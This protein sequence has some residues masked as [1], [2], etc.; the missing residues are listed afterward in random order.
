MHLD[1]ERDTAAT[2][3]T[4]EDPQAII[5]ARIWMCKYRSLAPL[6]D[7]R[8]LQALEIASY[9]DETLELV[10]GLAAL[11]DL[12]ILH[13]PKVTD[14]GPLARLDQLRSLALETTPRW[15]SSGKV[16]E[17][18]SLDPLSQLPHLSR[19][20]LYMA[21]FLAAAALTPSSAISP[22]ARCVSASTRRRRSSASCRSGTGRPLAGSRFRQERR[23]CSQAKA[24][25]FHALLFRVI[26]GG[27]CRRRTW[28][29]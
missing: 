19:L 16:S 2:F 27:R 17:V 23:P 25:F 14:L 28:R 26:L 4:L 29:S 21:W 8:N 1:L 10:G 3:P 6:A 24:A 9:P 12:R 15:D 7:A 13:M 20:T 22:S 18:E 5:S 11:E